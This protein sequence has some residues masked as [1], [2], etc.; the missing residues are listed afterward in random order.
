MKKIL[1]IIDMQKG[2]LVNKDN[3][4]TRDNFIK[5]LERNYFDYVIAT[6]YLNYD[7]S[8]FERLFNYTKLKK[9]EQISLDPAI[10]NY[11]NKIIDK[12]NYSCVNSGLLPLLIQANDGIFP[13]KIYVAGID[14]DSCVLNTVIDLFNANIIP[15]LIADCCSSSG[16]SEFH[17]AALKILK[18][19]I[20]SK[21]IIKAEDLSVHK[22]YNFQYYRTKF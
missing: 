4:K 7:N 13:E 5:F 8:L 17:E 14:T 1:V 9:E 21:Q 10:L 16:G 6:R 22:Y 12:T 18:R 15:I 20:G 3:F 11:V 19:M 2:F